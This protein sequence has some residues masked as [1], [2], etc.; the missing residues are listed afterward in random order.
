[1]EKY[2]HNLL[3]KEVNSLMADSFREK[4]YFVLQELRLHPCEMD[5]VIL[6]RNS[7]KISIFE[8]KRNNW[9]Y[10]LKQAKRT[11]LYSHYSVAVMPSTMKK[12]VPLKEFGKQGIGVAFY[13]YLDD[14]FDF[15]LVCKPEKSA[16]IN[17]GLKQLIYRSF[18]N[19]YGEALYA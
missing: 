2:R 5:L 7:L 3:E 4:G 13:N 10:L 16:E 9:N 6:D 17:R 14:K 1:M 18:Y 19:Q 15:Q 8:I 11:R 12:T